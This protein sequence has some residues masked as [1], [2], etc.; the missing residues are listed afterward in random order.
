MPYVVTAPPPGWFDRLTA[1]VLR[2]SEGPAIASRHPIV[3]SRAWP[4]PRCGDS[5]GRSLLCA[6]IAAPGHLITVC[7]THVDGGACQLAGLAGRL[8][9]RCATTPLVVLGDFNATDDAPGMGE[10]LAVAVSTTRF[11]T[12]IR[13][14]RARR[15]GSR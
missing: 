10:L 13:T 1:A 8:A 9:A 4:L 6:E 2:L 12:R 14:S 11:A 5:S 15:S 7:S 3:A